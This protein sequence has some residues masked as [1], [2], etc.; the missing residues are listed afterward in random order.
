MTGWDAAQ[1]RILQR[2]EGLGERAMVRGLER[3]GDAVIGQYHESIARGRSPAGK[4]AP[5][6]EPY[7]T[8]KKR[9]W[10]DRPILIASGSMIQSLGYQV[11]VLGPGRYR[12]NCG[13]GG[14][15]ANGVSNADKARWHIE[16]TRGRTA[17][18]QAEAK[19][20]RL[21]AREE[22]RSEHGSK[23]VARSLRRRASAISG[24]GGLPQRDFGRV[25]ARFLTIELTNALRAEVT[26]SAPVPALGGGPVGGEGL[27]LTLA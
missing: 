17:A 10:G 9:R 25:P 7:A 4:F 15:D 23:A 5:L 20:L 14:T 27:D 16:G 19:Q 12:L 18:A 6:S 21:A 2:L 26:G 24:S 8:R 22:S 11:T 1:R 3:V 13:A